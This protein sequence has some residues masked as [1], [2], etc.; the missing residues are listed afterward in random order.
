MSTDTSDDTTEAQSRSEHHADSDPRDVR[1]SRR[2]VE[3][4][5]RTH[6]VG[7]DNAMPASELAALPDVTVKATTVRDIITEIRHDEYGPPVGNRE[8]G[9]GYFVID[10]PDRLADQAARLERE[11]EHLLET[12]RQIVAS[13][14]RRQQEGQE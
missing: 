14:N 7:K 6:A 8:D 11:A 5:L 13:Y 2:A 1:D 12:K 9:A 3:A 4:A 10:S